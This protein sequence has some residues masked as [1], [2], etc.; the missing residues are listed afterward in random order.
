M[1]LS[2]IGTGSDYLSMYPSLNGQQGTPLPKMA[3]IV[4][5]FY[6]SIYV[7]IIYRDGILLP[8]YVS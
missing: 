3:P 1:Y 7:P 6:R 4:S 5:E 2:Y 8:V